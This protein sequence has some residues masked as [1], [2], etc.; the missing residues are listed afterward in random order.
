MTEAAAQ[1]TTT[2]RVNNNI[3]SYL[4]TIDS[5]AATE[6]AEIELPTSLKGVITGLRVVS[7]S[8]DFDVS[9]RT[10]T[11]VTAPSVQ[12]VLKVE[13]INLSYNEVELFIPY[14]CEVQL[15][16]LIT[17]TDASHATGEFQLE[18]LASINS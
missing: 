11:G 13:D 10:D 1:T 2:F 5:I 9:I 6:S 3:T 18:I 12:E 14:I 8:V 4:F 17:N 15:Y 16:A 7:D